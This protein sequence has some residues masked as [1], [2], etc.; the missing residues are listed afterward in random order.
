METST[1]LA[2]FLN[3][4]KRFGALLAALAI[5]LVASLA[6]TQLAGTA[7]AAQDSG[8]DAA[9]ALTG[10]TMT[11]QDTYALSVTPSNAKSKYEVYSTYLFYSTGLD[12]NLI[13]YNLYMEICRVG[14]DWSTARTVYFSSYLSTYTI[15]SLKASKKYKVRLYY[16]TTRYYYGQ[17]ITLRGPYSKTITFKTGTKKKPAVK[18]V[19]VRT[20]SYKKHWQRVYGYY[21]GLYLGKRAYWTYKIRTS[22]TLKKKPAGKYVIVNGKRFKAKKGKR[23]YTYTTKKYSSYY[24][25]KK[26]KWKVTVYSARNKTWKGYSKYYQ[27]RFKIR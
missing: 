3:A 9:P 24:N 20:V 11:T 2:T 12:S 7:Y 21:T 16:A 8:S 17:S 23:T 27:K 15:K 14:K 13:N 6:C 22:V 18:S 19:S 4:R 1:H 10:G 25:P 26:S 5:A